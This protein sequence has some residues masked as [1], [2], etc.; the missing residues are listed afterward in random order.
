MSWKY[1][2][3]AAL[4]LAASIPA[5]AQDAVV[6]VFGTELATRPA[7]PEPQESYGFNPNRSVITVPEWEGADS[8]TAWSQE[9]PGYLTAKSET[10]FVYAP[11]EFDNGVQVTRVC[12]DVQDA[13][14]TRS[15]TLIVGAFESGGAGAQPAFV[16]METVTTGDA[17]APGFTQI[18]ANVDPA[19]TIRTSADINGGGG[20]HTVQ[21]WVGAVQSKGSTTAIGPAVVTWRRTLSPGPATPTFL[22]VPPT[23]RFYRF[24][25]AL[26]AS[27]VTTGCG[28]GRFCPDEPLTRGEAAVFVAGALGMYWPN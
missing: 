6:T 25:E 9:H 12:L 1:A 22:D 7:D 24:V 21:Y 26:A 23:S 17:P 15:V 2:P 3:A 14:T 5:T 11:L 28:A 19:I 10:M 27:G 8:F 4:V 16:P 18:C 13:S 20:E